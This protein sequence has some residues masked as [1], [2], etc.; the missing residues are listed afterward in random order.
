VRPLDQRITLWMAIALL[1]L[2]TT[3]AVAWIVA[4]IWTPS[5]KPALVPQIQATLSMEAPHVRHAVN[6]TVL[7]ELEGHNATYEQAHDMLL[8][9]R[10]RIL[11]FGHSTPLEV[12]ATRGT[13]WQ[14]QGEAML[15]GNV[16]ATTPG[17]HISAQTLYYTEKNA[18][19]Q[20]SGSVVLESS[21]MQAQA[22]QVE[23][24][25]REER[26]IASGGVSAILHP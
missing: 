25:L 12:Q 23:V 11:Y 7:W 2:A 9:Q 5:P 4:H 10:P 14:K 20:L 24:S 1:A 3:V 6:G 13:L 22:P 17:Y 8:V 15:S 18:S 16:T 19:L 21:R 26:I